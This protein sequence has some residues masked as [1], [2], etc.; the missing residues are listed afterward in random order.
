MISGLSTATNE[1]PNF[2]FLRDAMPDARMML[3]RP[4][5]PAA[6]AGVARLATHGARARDGRR[7]QQ[8]SRVL[9]A[10]PSLQFGEHPTTFA[11]DDRIRLRS[12]PFPE[13]TRKKSERARIDIGPRGRRILC[14]RR[15]LRLA[16]LGL[17][18]LGSRPDPCDDVGISQQEKTIG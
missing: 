13:C 9:P 2:Q 15:R 8:S 4:S 3:F 11:A 16:A 10:R 1:F 12:R 5:L 7:R 14:P 6:A 17:P 18:C